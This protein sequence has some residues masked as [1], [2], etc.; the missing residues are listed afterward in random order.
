M[1]MMMM[2]TTWLFLL[3]LNVLLCCSRMSEE[4]DNCNN[5]LHLLENNKI[6]PF[7]VK[8]LD[9]LCRDQVSTTKALST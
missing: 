1:M 6:I 2:M 9:R 5:L 4:G 7:A 8:P 3:L